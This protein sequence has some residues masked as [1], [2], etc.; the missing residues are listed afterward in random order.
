MGPAYPDMNNHIVGMYFFNF[1]PRNPSD[2]SG[3]EGSVTG[4]RKFGYFPVTGITVE[5]HSVSGAAAGGNACMNLTN[6]GY[7]VAFHYPATSGL[8]DADRESRATVTGAAPCRTRMTD[9]TVMQEIAPT[10]QG[11]D[12][13][14]AEQRQALG[15][16]AENIFENFDQMDRQ[17][18]RQIR[19]GL[20]SL[21][22][23]RA[24][25][26]ALPPGQH[27]SEDQRL[28]YIRRVNCDIM[29]NLE[30]SEQDKNNRSNL[31]AH[32][33]RE[34]GAPLATGRCRAF[35]TH[36]LDGVDPVRKAK[37]EA[38]LNLTE[39]EATNHAFQ[40]MNCA[41]PPSLEQ[42]VPGPAGPPAPGG[43]AGTAI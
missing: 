27:P 29:R 5:G 43:K 25:L 19:T 35:L 16:L 9:N 20:D 39:P 10:S 7:P 33:Q 24:G 28:R 6:I 21:R 14:T 2:V 36:A 31:L 42:V 23:Y 26:A 30:G 41:N 1:D 22:R 12:A 37:V 18:T 8:S 40:T 4:T 11:A 38:F 13:R 32:F 15:I 17:I 34:F 3:L